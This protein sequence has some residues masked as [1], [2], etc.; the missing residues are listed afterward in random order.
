MSS[1]RCSFSEILPITWL[2]EMMGPQI[3]FADA[4]SSFIPQDIMNLTGGTC[5]HEDGGD[6]AV[7]EAV[8]PSLKEEFKVHTYG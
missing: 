7:F 1:C 8:D 4:R 3:T 5:I 6:I 2:E